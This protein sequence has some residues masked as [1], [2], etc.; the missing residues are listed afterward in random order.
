MRKHIRLIHEVKDE[1][2]LCGVCGKI[3]PNKRSMVHH[4][5]IHKDRIY[6]CKYENCPKKYFKESHLVE[7]EK[8]HINQREYKCT[9]TGCNKSYFKP[10][11]LKMHIALT[12]ENFKHPCPVP[13]CKFSVGRRDYMKSHVAKH[14]ELGP[15]L[16][17]SLL[18]EVKRNTNLW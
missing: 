7:H 12:H 10:R 4:K 15:H 16:V 6:V 17:E 11:V 13:D 1:K 14:T 18:D 2:Q 3:L 8:T 5:R 9:Y